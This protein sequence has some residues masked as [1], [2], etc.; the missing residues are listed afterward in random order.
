MLR[1]G[2]DSF[3][4]RFN[5]N[6]AQVRNKKMELRLA[7]VNDIHKSRYSL[8]AFAFNKLPRQL[9]SPL[10]EVLENHDFRASAS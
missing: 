6:R 1:A 4:T 8:Q 9:V 2:L 10:K 3:I 7:F 5:K